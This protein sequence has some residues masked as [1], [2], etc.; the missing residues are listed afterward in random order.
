MTT[1]DDVGAL[2]LSDKPEPPSAPAASSGDTPRPGWEAGGLRRFSALDGIRA[3]A[4]MAVIFY[5]AGISWV[6]GGL[7]GV[8]VFFVLSGFLIT[9]LLCR[10]LSRSA[11]LRLGRFWAQRARRLLPG[12]IIL[13]LGVAVYAYAFRD[14]VDLGL[15][16]GDALST[17]FYVANW[18]FI[19]ADQG[20]FVQA[21]APSPLLHTWSLAV[22]EQYYL[23]WP[24]VALFVVR[25][26]GIR[27]LAVTAGVGVVA[28]A[29][30]MG[31]L[32]TVGTSVDRLYYGTDTRVQALLVGSLLGAIGSH[33]GESFSILPDRWASSAWRRRLCVA[34]GLGGAAYLVWAWHALQGQDPFLYRGGFLVV[35]LAAGAVIVA[36]VTAP[37]ALM[38]RFLSLPVLVFI[39]RISYGLY[40][41]HWPLFLVIDHGHTGLSGAWLLVVRLAV[42]FTV[43]T[44]SF[45]FIEEPIRTRRAFLRQVR[46]RS[47]G[48]GR[49]RH[50]VGRPRSD[51]GSRRRRGVQ[52]DRG[53]TAAGRTA[54]LVSSGA[55]SS[56]PIRFVITG[57][58]VA[59]TL[60]I[61]LTHDS[62]QRY[63]VRVYDGG[64]PGCDLDHVDVITSGTVGG[65]TP[66]CTDW[67]TL[68]KSGVDRIRPDVVGVLLGRWETSDHLWHGQWVHVGDPAW[69]QH[70]VGEL[71]QVADILS[72][73]GAKVIFFTSPYVDPSGE[74][75]NGT[76]YPENDPS[77]MK[78]WNQL[79]REAAAQRKGTVTVVDL[80]KLLDPG[81][82]F[83]TDVDGYQVR[84][85]DGIHI[86]TDGGELAQPWIMPVVDQLGLAS[87]ARM[88]R[89]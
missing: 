18:H 72:S 9:S 3:F 15:I 6:G 74:A 71:V 24:L 52:Q 19:V 73:T 1:H 70:L 82:H 85:S 58:S 32:Y 89:R 54:G 7:L 79:V 46:P 16:R 20:Y 27:A 30:L 2:A 45:I 35:A 66:G 11:T 25:R 39:G 38:A 51:G 61:G 40:L 56:D 60:G 12:M 48:R 50:G 17:L 77:R 23:V 31:A 84:S 67:R 75:A 26:F 22:E 33:R 5:H 69:D 49:R 68:F 29:T 59:L 62:V 57:D 42:T 87:A 10:E 41:Y 14:S 44:V 47:G 80:N 53:P 34:V 86:T 65:P 63:G 36:C 83:Q 81:G 13:L 28:S 4:V 64:L 55:F 78:I 43:A 37:G 8:D 76:S 88:A 21:A